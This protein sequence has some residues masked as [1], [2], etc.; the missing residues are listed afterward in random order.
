[1][2]NVISC[3]INGLRNKIEKLE[4]LI[5]HIETPNVFNSNTHNIIC[6]QET[7]LH[8][9]FNLKLVDIP[10]YNAYHSF[11]RKKGYSG[12]SV[13]INFTP[14]NIVFPSWDTEGRL[15]ILELGDLVVINVYIPNAGEKLKRMDF[16][17]EWVHDF[18]NMINSINMPYIIVGDFNLTASRLHKD[19]YKPCPR[20]PGNTDIELN[21]YQT[22]LKQTNTIDGFRYLYPNTIQYTYWSN[23]H[24]SR[25]KNNG[26][27]LDYILIPKN[28]INKL[29][30]VKVLNDLSFIISDHAPF[31][32]YIKMD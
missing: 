28:I 25:E 20:S 10:N 4:Y 22:L 1:M 9:E 13:Y 31:I 15:I 11:A 29:I 2:Y 7:K 5:N 12:T 21:M 23:F 18:I 8:N 24:K 26:W 6:L 16:K 19:I 30:D 14:K 27:R 17:I 3:N 32:A